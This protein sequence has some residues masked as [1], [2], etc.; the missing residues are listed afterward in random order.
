MLQRFIFSISHF[1]ISKDSNIHCLN[2]WD[3][4]ASVLGKE[5]EILHKKEVDGVILRFIL[6]QYLSDHCSEGKLEERIRHKLEKD[7][8]HDYQQDDDH[9]IQITTQGP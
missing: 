2:Q 4:P 9:K 3:N 8:L 7:R 1:H 6:I 5:Y